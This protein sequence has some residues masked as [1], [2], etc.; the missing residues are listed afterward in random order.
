MGFLPV[1]CLGLW[2]VG[3]TLKDDALVNFQAGGGHCSPKHRRGIHNDSSA[4]EQISFDSA[5]ND[6]GFGLNLGLDMGALA[7]DQGVFRE[8]LTFE[9]PANLDG[10]F[11]G[12]SP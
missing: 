3:R 5:R 1:Y 10:A 9:A 8:N 12:E 4:S 11:K 6:N 7:H 2:H